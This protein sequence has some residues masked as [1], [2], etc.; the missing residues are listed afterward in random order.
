MKLLNTESESEIYL[1]RHTLRWNW[2]KII[3]EF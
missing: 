2:K 3:H 1:I